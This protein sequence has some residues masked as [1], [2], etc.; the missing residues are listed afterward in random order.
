ML[1]LEVALQ[2]RRSSSVIKRLSELHEEA[3]RIRLIDG[4]L[5][6]HK[7]IATRAPVETVAAIARCYPRALDM[8][9][10]GP[11][12][13]AAAKAPHSQHTR[14]D[15][16]DD[17]VANENFEAR[18]KSSRHKNNNYDGSASSKS[19][20]PPWDTRATSRKREQQ[21]QHDSKADT[22]L[23][24]ALRSLAPDPVIRWLLSQPSVQK[25]VKRRDEDGHYPIHKALLEHQSVSESTLLALVESDGSTK[26]DPVNERGQS[27]DNKHRNLITDKTHAGFATHRK[28][29]PVCAKTIHGDTS[30][31]LAIELAS[32]NRPKLRRLKNCTSKGTRS[33]IT[34][35][36]LL[37]MLK[38]APDLASAKSSRG[39]P[40][41]QAAL[42]CCFPRHPSF[43]LELLNLAPMG[44]SVVMRSSRDGH[45]VSPLHVAL[46]SLQTKKL[47]DASTNEN[48]IIESEKT[49]TAVILEVLMRL[50]SCSSADIL[51]LPSGDNKMIPLHEALKASTFFSHVGCGRRNNEPTYTTFLIHLLAAAPATARCFTLKGESPFLIALKHRAPSAALE[52]IAKEAPELVIVAPQGNDAR[53]SKA[54][55]GGFSQATALLA[56]CPQRSHEILRMAQNLPRNQQFAYRYHNKALS[57]P[58][59]IVPLIDKKASEGNGRGASSGIIEMRPTAFEAET[60]AHGL[61]RLNT[62]REGS[63]LRRS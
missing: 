3:A 15:E 33:A 19:M 13:L 55:S 35:R 21:D 17:D 54:L 32:Q 58:S 60:R 24:L 63:P 30:M 40:T 48:G 52:R 34:E 51:T 10:L 1:P 16:E 11:S 50:L 18:V 45:P 29:S 53:S 26:K 4:S 23:H 9:C 37:H 31:A 7:A 56:A 25:S 5:P 20:P 49:D 41:L 39:E 6:L 27:L 57:K 44:A 42:R 12:S 43:V 62:A 47:P 61:I 22:T 36:L 59:S 46:R 8:P 2:F 28:F 38:F 14:S